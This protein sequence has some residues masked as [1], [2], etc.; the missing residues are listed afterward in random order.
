LTNVPIAPI[1]KGGPEYRYAGR[2]GLEEP[3]RMAEGSDPLDRAVASWTEEDVRTILSSPAYLQPRHPKHRQVQRDVRAWFE[4]RFGTG[5]SP[6]DATGR[7][8][9]TRKTTERGGGC[10]V[11]VRAHNRG[12]VEVRAHC[13]STPA[14]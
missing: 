1:E 13:R 14:G 7:A 4:R 2:S 5:P 6:V 11:P 8:R 10:A 12:N 9:G 3:T